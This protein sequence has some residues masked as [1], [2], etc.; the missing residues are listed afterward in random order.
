MSSM[1]KN[2]FGIKGIFANY[3]SGELFKDFGIPVSCGI[4]FA[5]FQYINKESLADN[6]NNLL[7]YAIVYLPVMA[8]IILTAYTM[9]I[10]ALKSSLDVNRVLD[11]LSEKGCLQDEVTT[12]SKIEDLKISI[13]ASFA[14]SIFISVIALG[15]CWIIYFVKG[16]HL[17][18]QYACQINIVCYGL[19]IAMI[20][21]PIVAIIGIVS[22]LFSISRI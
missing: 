16:F 12:K 6:L 10:G 20:I 4:V 19:I 3:T 22:D 15:L 8:T 2:D 13:S 17:P 9:M 21:Y 11:N 18:S 5:I 14:A 7:E 1:N